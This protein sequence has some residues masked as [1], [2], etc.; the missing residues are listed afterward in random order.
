MWVTMVVL[1]TSVMTSGC[2]QIFKV[3]GWNDYHYA[4][5][6]KADAE[7]KAEYDAKMAA[8]NK[9]HPT[10]PALSAKYARDNSEYICQ[11][12]EG[13]AGNYVLARKAGSQTR[14]KRMFS[15]HV[16]EQEEMISF[17]NKLNDLIYNNVDAADKYVNSKAFF[18]ECLSTRSFVIR[19]LYSN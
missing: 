7:H 13:A 11:L 14:P 3:A 6:V 19:K 17:L 9:A 2:E 16:D 8:Y 18:K 15:D 1:S 4:E 5:K 10:S 12:Q